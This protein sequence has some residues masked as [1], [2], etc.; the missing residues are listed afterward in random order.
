[1]HG[2]ACLVALRG[3]WGLPA[4]PKTLVVPLQWRIGLRIG[5]RHGGGGIPLSQQS[6]HCGAPLEVV[7]PPL[8]DSECWLL[9][10]LVSSLLL[11][12]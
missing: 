4:P 7:L 8:E 3:A 2:A 12:L 6:A 11:F 1:V 10:L 5:L 9:L